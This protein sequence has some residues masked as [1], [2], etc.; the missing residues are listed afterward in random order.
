MS[1]ASAVV[2]LQTALSLLTLVN[3]NPTL[4]Q[5]MRDNAQQVA[6]QVIAQVTQ[7]QI[8]QLVT[9]IDADKSFQVKTLDS[10]YFVSHDDV[11]DGGQ[12]LTGY[13]KNGHVQKIDYSVGLSL[14]L[15][16]YLYYF[17]RGELV[18]V[19]AEED[20]FP[21]TDEGFDYKNIEPV[22]SC[23]YFFQNGKLLMTNSKGEGRYLSASTTNPGDVLMA[24]AERYI[25]LLSK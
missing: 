23:E 2:L 24:R 5:S 7:A 25:A 11:M 9:A 17:D 4:P 6:Q 14:G 22:F 10:D 12:E 13:F 20:D 8:Q 16:K 19:S 3:S 21:A 15:Q 1:L 18:Y